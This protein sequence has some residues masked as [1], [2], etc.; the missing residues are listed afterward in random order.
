MSVPQTKVERAK[1][2]FCSLSPCCLDPFWGKRAQEKVKAGEWDFKAVTLEYFQSFRPVSLREEQY[3]TIQR[4]VAGGERGKAHIGVRQRAQSV[5]L[6]V[7]RHFESRGGRKLD[8]APV[9]VQKAYKT[10]RKNKGERFARPKQFGNT[11]FFY[12]NSQLKEKGGGAADHKAAWLALPPEGKEWWK[13]RHHNSVQRKR[14]QEKME[15]ASRLAQP[16]APIA[17]SWNLG[18][19]D[20]PLKPSIVSQFL[21]MFQTKQAGLKTLKEI[22]AAEN[23]ENILSYV[24]SVESGSTQYH[25][26]DAMLLYCNRFLGGSLD[27]EAMRS[28]EVTRQILSAEVPQRGCHALHPGMCQTRDAG[29]KAGV[30]ALFK[31]VPKTSCVLQFKS[32][33]VVLFVRSVL[34]R[35]RLQAV[36]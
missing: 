36:G 14:R 16:S 5:A 17:T 28:C 3:H 32:P 35:I 1:E 34:G 18:E 19:A 6:C 23:P 11:M 24:E 22:I 25:F 10:V 21:R 29:K 20:W 12:I 33:K 31:I 7:K 2:E 4:Q 26:R 13:T 15:Q 8:T 30:S 9:K 27:H